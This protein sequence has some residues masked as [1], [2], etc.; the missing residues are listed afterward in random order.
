MKISRATPLNDLL[1]RLIFLVLPTAAIG[2][3][4][5]DAA[6]SYFAILQN[7]A[8]LQAAYFGGGMAAAMVF[9]AF[10]FRFLITFAALIALLHFAYKGIGAAAVGEFDAFFASIQFL[11]FAL[12][13]GAGWL[14][15]WG[16]LRMRY[17]AVGIA[18]VLLASCIGV[19]A[20]QQFESVRDLLRPF[21][22]A[23]LYAVY[24]IFAGEQ[25]WNYRDKG[26]KFWSFL[27][28]RLAGFGL[29]AGALLAGTLWLLRDELKET[30]ENYGGGGK[31][32]KNSMLARK[33]DGTFSLKNYSRL[34][35]SL[36]RSNDLLF[37]AHIDNFFP[38]TETPNPLYL[39]A[40]Y[41]T[42][43]DTSTETFER[44]DRIPRN[45]LFEPNPAAIPLF[46]TRTDSS[47]LEVAK[48][49]KLRRVIDM[50]VYSV[51]LSPTQYL[52]PHTGFF[53][54][55][56]TVE[57]DFR[58]QFKTAFRAK[59][60]VSE[61]NSAY[62]IYNSKEPELRT[63][64]EQRFEVLRRVKDFGGTD[65][66][67]LRYYTYMPAHPKW[68]R[69]T[70]LAQGVTAN[71]R[72]P[73]DK[74]LAIRDYF[75]GTDSSG[76]PLFKYTDNPG[77]PGLPSASKLL[78]FLFENRK[79]YCAYYAGATLFMLRSLGIP[80][81]IAVGF[82]TED[83]SDKNP[84][85]YW[86]YADQAHA[87]VQVY[88]PGYGWLDFDTTVGNTEAQQSPQTDG[89]P[90]TQPPRALLA[91]DGI[92]TAV[93]TAE[94]R[95]TMKVSRMVYKDVEYTLP[96][97]RA[98]ELD[99][100]IAAIRRDSVDVPLS[101]VRPGTEATAVSYAEA[102]AP[103]TAK[104][105][106]AAPSILARFPKPAP[107]DEVYLK[108]K[109][110]KEKKD[111]PPPALAEHRN[112]WVTAGIVGGCIVILLTVLYFLFPTLLSAY[113]RSRARSGRTASARAYWAYTAAGH[114]LHQL[115]LPRSDA[116]TP[117][118]YAE[119]VVRPAVGMRFAQFLPLYLRTKYA[120]NASVAAADAVRMDEFLPQFL[121]EA[122][123]RFRRKARAVAFL[124][125][126]RTL[127]FLRRGMG[128]RA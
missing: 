53:V 128:A 113:Y 91:A 92:I 13:F 26:R 40:F 108:Q 73:V 46:G 67:F 5:L 87:W 30:V 123:S 103:I 19:I 105:G 36:G 114:Y 69:I 64:Q 33:K 10:R 27:G 48:D 66:A 115:G 99:V 109:G 126:G 32:G 17:W 34:Q 116:Q 112:P 39:T 85:W 80:S 55:P 45:D 7:R 22:P 58:E 28:V 8:V 118:Q 125:P 6:N 63:F 93:D 12:L 57:K 42:K 86:Y 81:R 83:R 110:E 76:A 117:T 120:P 104:P 84:G 90:P 89:T 121:A 31:G 16:F 9:Y 35:S 70:A 2:Y 47:V 97:P 82:L 127:A 52:A 68:G 98:L 88:F 74:V 65:P 20:K 77:V 79:G 124:K 14:V 111:T 61:L 54:Q 23:A 122:N 56:I 15:G 75:L 1:A 44:D 18:A 21:V 41:Y 24:I 3:F 94:K 71:A 60:Y 49:D 59:S 78:Y 37:A 72:T 62:F 11:V 106:E 25:I 50:E 101:T 119:A 43:F 29:L 107:I 96:Q 51:K 95:M 38:G 100:H 4:L 102:F